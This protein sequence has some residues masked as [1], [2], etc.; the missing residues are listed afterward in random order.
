MAFK[1]DSEERFLSDITLN[2]DGTL[3]YQLVG[4]QGQ[5]IIFDVSGDGELKMRYV[6]SGLPEYGGYGLLRID[7]LFAFMS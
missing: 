2:H 1:D 5:V 3:L 6:V 7:E 4:N